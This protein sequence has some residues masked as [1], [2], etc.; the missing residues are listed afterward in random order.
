MITMPYTTKNCINC[1]KYSGNVTF[2]FDFSPNIYVSCHDCYDYVQSTII[3]ETEFLRGIILHYNYF[4]ND[5]EHC[6]FD[7]QHPLGAPQHQTIATIPTIIRSD[8][9]QTKVALTSILKHHIEIDKDQ[10]FVPTFFVEKIGRRNIAS[11]KKYNLDMLYKENPGIIGYYEIDINKYPHFNQEQK[12]MIEQHNTTLFKK[13]LQH[14]DMATDLISLQSED[15]S[16]IGWLPEEL[17]YIILR[18]VLNSK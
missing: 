16:Y 13:M 10:Y 18:F 7:H 15:T 11:V 5:T 12:S 1:N 4:G 17:L 14:N 3:P 6:L 2:G 9:T 8:Q